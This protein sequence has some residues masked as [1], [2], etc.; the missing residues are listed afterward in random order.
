[1]WLLATFENP[2]MTALAVFGKIS[3]NEEVFS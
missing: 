1:M 3:S 2:L